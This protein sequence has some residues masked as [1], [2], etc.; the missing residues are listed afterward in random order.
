MALI[1]NTVRNVVAVHPN[2]MIRVYKKPASPII[3][4]IL[5]NNTTLKIF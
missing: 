2:N 1:D 4:D 3:V 5:K